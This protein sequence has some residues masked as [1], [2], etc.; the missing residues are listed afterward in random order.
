MLPGNSINECTDT[1]VKYHNGTSHYT[2]SV[3]LTKYAE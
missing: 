3:Q 2:R 1:W